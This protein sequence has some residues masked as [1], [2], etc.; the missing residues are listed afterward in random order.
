VLAL[1]VSTTGLYSILAFMV[2]T[3]W[4]EIGMRM[5]LGAHREDVLRLI[6]AQGMWVAAGG[7]GVGLIAA[8]ITTRLEA[9]LL[10]WVRATDP[11]TLAGVAGLLTLVAL[12][13]C[14]IPAGAPPPSIPPRRCAQNSRSAKVAAPWASQPA[15]AQTSLTSSPP[16]QFLRR[17]SWNP[18]EF[19]ARA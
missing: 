12:L 9:T 19:R 10:Y 13:A 2:R 15:H 8:L 18:T 6:V 17:T 14:W 5:A 7:V 16:S 3:R 11:G 1:S 4:R